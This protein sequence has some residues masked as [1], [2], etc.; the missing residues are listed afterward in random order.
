MCVFPYGR[1][2]RRSTGRPDCVGRARRGDRPTDGR[3]PS[4]VRGQDAGGQDRG[5]AETGAGPGGARQDQPAGAGTGQET[6][7]DRGRRVLAGEHGAGRRH[8]AAEPGGGRRL[9]QGQGFRGRHRQTGTLSFVRFLYNGADGR[10]TDQTTC[11]TS[12]AESV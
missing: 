1:T 4:G 9:G 10:P 11:A 12:A 7:A 2:G 8:Q 3:Q 6:G 5:R